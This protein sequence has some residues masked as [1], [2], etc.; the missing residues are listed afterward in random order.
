MTPEEYKWHI[1]LV[2]DRFNRFNLTF[3]QAEQVYLHEKE[4]IHSEK[5]FFSAWEEMDFN[6]TTF[7]KIL[8]KDQF[9]K[10]EKEQIEGIKNHESFL[11]ENDQPRKTDINYTKELINYDNNFLVDFF[12]GDDS[13]RI[14]AAYKDSNKIE[15]LKKEYKKFVEEKKKELLT[16][17]FRYYRSF[18]PNELELSLLRHKLLYLIPDYES[19]K[20]YTDKPSRAIADYLE[21]KLQHLDD[22]DEKTI[23]EKFMA[24]KN[25][26][27][28][29]FNKYY[30]KQQSADTY[31]VKGPVLT[32][33]QKM[34]YFAM[35]IL[36][37][38]E[39]RYGCRPS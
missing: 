24:L 32:S 13:L 29:C 4:N 6:L 31:Y 19:F 22:D 20:R 2:K 36:L 28:V 38:D 16:M 27:Q 5:H 26:H 14:L 23:S 3:A 33:T 17:H 1:N 11:I 30:G 15:Y 10:Y 39:E 18:K 25:F 35:T 34:T 7:R 12:N 37:L 21:E 8:N 9:L